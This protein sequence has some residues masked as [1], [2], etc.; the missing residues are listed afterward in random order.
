[1]GIP[2]Y[3]D[4]SA[5]QVGNNLAMTTGR[6]ILTTELFELLQYQPLSAD[7]F[8][9]PQLIVPPVVN[10]FYLVDM[11]PQQSMV[12]HMLQNGFQ[13]FAISW[14]NPNTAYRD[15]GLDAYVSAILDAIEAVR[16]VSGSDD[17]NLHGICGGA[18]IMAALLAY[19]AAVNQQHLVH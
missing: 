11:A 7:V 12:E 2:A 19:L 1:H 8:A 5:F 13:V 10:K 4:K 17:T 16:S 15:F 6:V 9:R 3:V 14:K 18:R